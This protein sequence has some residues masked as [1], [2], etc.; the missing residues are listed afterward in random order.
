M[1]GAAQNGHL[2]VVKYLTEHRLA[3]SRSE[4]ME[5]ACHYGHLKIVRYLHEQGCACDFAAMEEAIIHGHIQIVK[6]LHSHRMVRVT[7]NMV[8]L[9]MDSQHHKIVQYLRRR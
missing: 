4:T 7:K 9:A 1:D 8:R 3:T 5:L 6:Y 2:A